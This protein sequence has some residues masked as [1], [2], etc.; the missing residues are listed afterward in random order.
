MTLSFLKGENVQGPR[1][2]NSF[3]Y[4]SGQEQCHLSDKGTQPGKH[5]PALDSYLH[6]RIHSQILRSL[7]P[8]KTQGES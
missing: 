7:A 2:A 4:L 5:Q 8:P 6:L 3:F 1:R